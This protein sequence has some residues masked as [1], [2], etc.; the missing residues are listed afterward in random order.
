MLDHSSLR[1]IL[2]LPDQ[3]L[4]PRR[5]LT[6]MAP[7]APRKRQSLKPEDPL[8]ECDSAKNLRS[9]RFGD[10]YASTHDPIGESEHVFLNGNQLQ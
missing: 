5:L 8:A 4:D 10:I 6:V 2:I 3:N 9:E 7:S 1:R